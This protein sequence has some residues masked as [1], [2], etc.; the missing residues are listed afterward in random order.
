MKL[1]TLLI[2]IFAFSSFLYLWTTYSTTPTVPSVP[3]PAPVVPSKLKTIST[4]AGNFAYFIHQANLSKLTLHSNFPD[5]TDSQKL[6]L[7]NQCQFLTNGGFYSQ[8]YQH[9]GWMVV[10]GEVISPNLVSKLLDGYLVINDTAEIA[11]TRPQGLPDYGLQSGPMLIVDDNTIRLNIIDD[12]GRRR[13]IA[14]TTATDL[15]F[16]V[17][18]APDSLFSGP[19]LAD[20]PAV[21]SAIAAAENLSFSAAIN[22][23][24][25]SASAFFT[26]EIYLKELSPIGSFFCQK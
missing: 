5:L 19:K 26:Q 12:Q 24:G 11:F 20:T 16:L 22:L 7:Q 6:A 8:D 10:N 17:I 21:V 9:L 4:S 3:A 2:F 18:T 13:L 25:G 23:D 1:K 15:Y 14:A